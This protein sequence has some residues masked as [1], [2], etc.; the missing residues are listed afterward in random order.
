MGSPADWAAAYNTHLQCGFT[1]RTVMQM[2]DTPCSCHS[3]CVLHM[4]VEGGGLWMRDCMSLLGRVN[5]GGGRV[6]GMTV[7][8]LHTRLTIMC[9]ALTACRLVITE[10]TAL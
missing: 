9:T 7:M 10:T 6:S 4:T 2:S 5:S 1:A 8:V 3:P